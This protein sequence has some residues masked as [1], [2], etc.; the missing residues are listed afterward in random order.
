MPLSL[1]DSV[2]R[3]ISIEGQKFDVQNGY[4]K[5]TDLQFWEG[6]PRVY[7]LLQKHR[8]EKTI[9]KNI[10]FETMRMFPD[11]DKLKEQIRKDQ[12]INDPLWVC[13]NPETQEY[14]VYEGNTRLAI[15]IQLSENDTPDLRDNW[16][17]VQVNVLP[18][19]TD[20]KVIKRLIGLIHLVGVNAW[21]PF[22]ADG[23]YYREVQ[24]L[25]DD[26]KSLD[27]STKQVAKTYGVSSSK[28]KSAYTLVG[29]MKH[30]NMSSNVQKNYYSYWQTIIQN[31][32]LTKIRKLF[33]NPQFTKGKI[34]QSKPDAF[35]KMLI[36][37]V[38]DGI[39][40]QRVSGSSS[41]GTTFRD[42]IKIICNAYNEKDGIELIANLIDE[43]ITI[44]RAVEMAKEGGIGN[45]EYDKVKI[46]ADWLC[47][48]QTMKNIQNAVINYPGMKEAVELIF[49]RSQIAT[50]KLEENL[51]KKSHKLENTNPY[52]LMYKLCILMMLADRIPHPKE[53]KLIEKI[54]DSQNWIIDFENHDIVDAI[55]QVSLD[56][57]KYDGVEHTA[58][59]YGKQLVKREHQLK[60][61]SIIEKVMFA[62][63]EM[64][65]EET[66]L[67]KQLK[68]LW[69]I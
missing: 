24:D 56:I 68:N 1:S 32:P 27:D 52:H 59:I 46:F 4:A 58:N 67:I 25:R 54:L 30:H 63:N 29:F 15:A 51:R 47:S 65:K 31:K 36:K 69:N 13:R 35:D 66:M 33:N 2:S 39:E 12:L 40:V 34:E 64:K 10:I 62:D 60:I 42:D 44:Q 55:D 22:E 28:V 57:H 50:M 61:L 11:F 41:D 21:A 26:G 20:E 14:T 45:T 5:I 8:D 6:N 43:K 16:H 48:A 7:S 38:K 53:L 17:K 49:E 23:Y 3:R 37:K 18:D 9:T 19:G